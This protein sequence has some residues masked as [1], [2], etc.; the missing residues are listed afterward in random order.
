[1]LDGR[2]K[3]LPPMAERLRGARMRAPQQFVNQSPWDGTTAGQEADSRT[4]H[5]G[6]H[7]RR[8][9]DRRCV[10][11]KCGRA[12]ADAARQYC[13]AV[14]KRAI[15]QVAVSVHAVTGPG[16]CALNRQLYLPRE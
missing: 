9:G 4:A 1:M 12:S 6:G 13:G 8:V 5:R 14:G 2:R 3:S 11:P 10:V 15:C 7:A 16:S